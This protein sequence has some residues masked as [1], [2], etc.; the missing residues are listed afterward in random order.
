MM[1]RRGLSFL[2]P[3]GS[4]SA[5]ASTSPRGAR[6]CRC[7]RGTVA[8]SSRRAGRQTAGMKRRHRPVIPVAVS[9]F[10]GFGFPSEVIMLAVRWYL[11][12]G[13]SYRDLEE[14]MAERGIDVDHVTLYWCFSRW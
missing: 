2:S 12:F 5:T 11:R 1:M 9:A 8:L 4:S 7:S 14:L 6:S 13:L 10:A 3:S